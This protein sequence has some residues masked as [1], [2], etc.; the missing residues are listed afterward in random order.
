MTTRVDTHTVFMRLSLLVVVLLVGGCVTAGGL[1]GSPGPSSTDISSP[2]VTDA[3]SAA[4]AA[5]GCGL[6]NESIDYGPLDLNSMVGYGWRFVLGKVDAIEPAMFNTPDG[7][8]PRG[9]N[10]K[11]SSI[12]QLQTTAQIF[13]PVV[14]HVDQVLYGDV[15]SGSSRFLIEGGTVGCY[16]VRIDVA[17]TVEKGARY[18]FVLSDAPDANG[19]KLSDAQLLRF[20]VPVGADN[21]VNIFGTWMTPDQLAERL[22]RSSP[23]P[24]P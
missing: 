14:V 19:K 23:P 18:V 20:A 1:D 4:E 7:K 24:A 21:T 22:A 16:T 13:T 9:F 12:E 8:R 2:G 6:A 10:A 17:P 11:P 15:K 3:A 5:G